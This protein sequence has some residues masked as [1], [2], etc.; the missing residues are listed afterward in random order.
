MGKRARR[1]ITRGGKVIVGTVNS[2]VGGKSSD[3]GAGPTNLIGAKGKRGRRKRVN[4]HAHAHEIPWSSPKGISEG[5]KKKN[6]G[7]GQ[8]QRS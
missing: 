1:A 8:I 6:E 2:S 4:G 3:A 7:Q 5:G